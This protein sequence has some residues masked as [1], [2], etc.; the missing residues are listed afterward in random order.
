MYVVNVID[1]MTNHGSLVVTIITV[2]SM[3][4]N[5]SHHSDLWPLTSAWCFP[6]RDWLWRRFGIILCEPWVFELFLSQ[7]D[8]LT[9]SESSSPRAHASVHWLLSYVCWTSAQ[10]CYLMK[11]A[12]DNRKLARLQYTCIPIGSV[13][14][15]SAAIKRRPCDRSDPLV[16]PPHLHPLILFFCDKTRCCLWWLLNKE[17]AVFSCNLS[18]PES[19]TWHMSGCDKWWRVPVISAPTP[20]RCPKPQ[21]QML[22]LN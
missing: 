3:V 20:L 14:H 16:S 8:A 10:T 21:S 13:L 5:Q 4:S 15:S 7:S 1:Y 11:V 12:A 9:F 2:P 22:L 18:A 17:R 6:P 19:G